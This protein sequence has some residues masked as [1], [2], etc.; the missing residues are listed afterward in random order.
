M[1]SFKLYNNRVTNYER[2]HLLAAPTVRSREPHS[3]VTSIAA[4]PGLR[5]GPA[6]GL[7]FGAR[8][9]QLRAFPTLETVTLAAE[10]VREKMH[11]EQLWVHEA[12]EEC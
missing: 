5:I 9:F 12:L 10:T 4:R 1:S 6:Q 8:G 7:R 3:D 11:L 2:A